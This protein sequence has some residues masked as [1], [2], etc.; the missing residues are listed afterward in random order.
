MVPTNQSVSVRQFATPEAGSGLDWK[1]V[2]FRVTLAWEVAA[3]EEASKDSP[4]SWK[5]L[6]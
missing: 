1:D 2:S 3:G 5:N 4:E 6:R